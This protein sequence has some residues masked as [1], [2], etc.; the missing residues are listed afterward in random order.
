[1]LCGAQI[2]EDIYLSYGNRSGDGAPVTNYLWN[3]EFKL[4]SLPLAYNMSAVGRGLELNTAFTFTYERLAFF[5][6]DMLQW[7][8]H[9]WTNFTI[10]I[11]IA[12]AAPPG[13]KYIFEWYPVAFGWYAPYNLSGQYDQS[14][15]PSEGP[16][17][18]LNPQD[19]QTN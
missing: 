13:S 5:L 15:G 8:E 14:E 2:E 9:P 12:G 18:I 7:M 1:M 19:P 6:G 3:E 17:L 10:E 16:H 4:E 11:S